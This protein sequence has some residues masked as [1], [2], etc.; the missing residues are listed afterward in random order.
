MCM[1]N[2]YLR[3][4]SG[5]ALSNM[6]DKIDAMGKLMEQGETKVF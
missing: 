5:F 3:G 6:Y 1:W 4:D 2:D